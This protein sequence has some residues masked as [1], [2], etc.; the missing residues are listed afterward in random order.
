MEIKVV[1]TVPVLERAVLLP[2]SRFHEA[3][4]CPESPERLQI[5][6]LM[7]VVEPPESYQLSDIG[8]AVP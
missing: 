1:V 8:D 6:L 7:T 3:A 4:L 2:P 5:P